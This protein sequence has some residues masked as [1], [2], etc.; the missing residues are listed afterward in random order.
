MAIKCESCDGFRFSGETL[1]ILW[2]GMNI[3]EVLN[4][5]ID[6]ACVF[7][8]NHRKIYSALSL[9]SQFGLGYLRLGQASSTL[10]GGEAQRLKLIAELQKDKESE[11]TLYVFDEP[12]VGLHMSDVTNLLNIFKTLI[13]NGNTIIVIEHNADVWIKS[14]WVI[15]LGPSGGN[16]GGF[17]LSQCAPNELINQKTPTG[18]VLKKC[19]L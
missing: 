15:E 7:F 10:S 8:K 16:N 9:M 18:D 3:A 6:T 12:T 19:V 5:S 14:D 4:M 11:R 2:Q 13:K 17:L 1:S